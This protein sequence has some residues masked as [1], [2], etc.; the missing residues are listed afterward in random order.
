M[1]FI[2]GFIAYVLVLMKDVWDPMSSKQT[3]LAAFLFQRLAD[4]YP[5]ITSESKHTKVPPRFLC[6]NPVCKTLSTVKPLEN[7]RFCIECLLEA[8][9]N[10]SRN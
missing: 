10:E 3:K 9:S 4:D 7:S 2:V 6:T 8:A 5:T 1:I